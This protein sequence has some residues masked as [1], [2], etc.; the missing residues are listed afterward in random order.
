VKY[1]NYLVI[2]VFGNSV[3]YQTVKYREPNTSSS[4]SSSSSSKWRRISKQ[5]EKWQL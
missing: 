4:S 2:T 3:R 5:S 1:F